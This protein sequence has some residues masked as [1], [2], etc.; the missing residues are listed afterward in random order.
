MQK[1]LTFDFCKMM[2]PITIKEFYQDILRNCCPDI[3]LFLEENINKDIGHFNVFDIA[4]LYKKCKLKP[5]M[6]YNRRTYYK[7]S[8]ISGKNKVEYADKTIEIEDYAILFASPKIPYNFTP[9]STNQSG[10]FCVFTKEYL[11]KFNIGLDI[12]ALPIFLPKSNFVYQINQEQFQYINAIFLKMHSEIASDYEYKYDLLRN[13]LMELIHYGQKLNPME[14]TKNNK[15][16]ATRTTSLF[17]ELLE[18]QFPIESISQHL[19]LKT[20]K[21]Y[22]NTLGVHVN[23]LNRVLKETTGKTTGEIIGSRIFQEAKTLLTQTQWNI[24]EI[25]FTLGFE[26]V[27]HFSNFF[28]KHSNKSPQLFRG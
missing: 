14:P 15:T 9:T 23:H 22:A 27:A 4:E 17:I 6:P 12:D 20:P 7:V 8:L 10:H 11:S 2:T 26:E 5:E 18:R 25:A 1:T 16:A 24:S 3:D 13:Y 21:D 28:K 19:Q